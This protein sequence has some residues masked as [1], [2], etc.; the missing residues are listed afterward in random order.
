MGTYSASLFSGSPHPTTC[1]ICMDDW[2]EVSGDIVLTPCLH[3]FH[4][5]CLRGWLARCVDCPSCRWDISKL[6]DQGRPAPPGSLVER[7]PLGDLA[8]TVV[9]IDDDSQD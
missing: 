1:P 5:T 9:T 6:G 4:E 7:P 2:T 8:G 3:V